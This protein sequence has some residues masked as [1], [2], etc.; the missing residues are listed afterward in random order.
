VK[1]LV[2]AGGGTGGHVY[3]ALAVA[4][5]FCDQTPDG[6]VLFIGN[7]NRREAALIPSLGLSFEGLCFS[8]LP[9]KNLLAVI[10]WLW[11][12]LRATWRAR[13]V[14]K[15][16][17]PDVVFTAGGYVTAPVIL[18]AWCLRIPFILHEPDANPGLV[19]R[20]FAPLAH[21]VT[22]AFE[23][24]TTRMKARA[25]SVTGNPLRGEIGA[26]APEDALAQLKMPLDL[27]RPVLLVT[28]GSQGARHINQAVLDALPVL[29][30]RGV[31][32]IHQ[33]GEA[34]FDEVNRALPHKPEGYYPVPFI[35][36][37][38]AALGVATLALARAGSMTLSE[39]AQSHVPTL[40]AP[41]PFAAADHQRKNAYAAEALGM[42]R[43]IEDAQLTG[44]TLSRAVFEVLDTPGLLAQMKAATDQLAR[45]KA[46]SEILSLLASLKG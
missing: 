17:S 30:A 15:A 31:Q 1:R 23:A 16:F 42:S 32:V 41:Y 18:A 36:A 22:C 13:R 33:T 28:G 25:F 4:Q 12:F 40:L 9:R 24:A 5:A 39:M 20:V 46:T 7:Q 11:Q 26:I 37:M 19:N 38:G 44:E 35:G 43:V 34:L 21:R 27:S 45:P 10:P 29:L 3:P 6:A 2:V 8:G 14:L